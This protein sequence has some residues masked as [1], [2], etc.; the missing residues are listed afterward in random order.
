VGQQT[1]EVQSAT[2]VGEHAK[3]V[4]QVRQEIFA[5][6]RAMVEELEP[7]AQQWQGSA[8][9][10][11]QRLKV[12]YTE[13]HTGLDKVLGQIATALAANQTNY[14][15]AEDESNQALTRVNAATSSIQNKMN[16]Q[17]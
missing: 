15:T 7:V 16:P 13:K 8:A 9:S 6:L 17:V 1:F 5:Q 3:H 12:D 14:S 4:D 11:F 2:L 10:A